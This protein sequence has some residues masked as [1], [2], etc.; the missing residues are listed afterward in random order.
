ML[1]N[2][3][4]VNNKNPDLKL[5]LGRT[6]SARYWGI[7]VFEALLCGADHFIYDL[8]CWLH[9]LFD[10][11][12]SVCVGLPWLVYFDRSCELKGRTWI[13]AL[14]SPMS[15][16]RLSRLFSGCFCSSRSWGIF[17]CLVSCNLKRII[18]HVSKWKRSLWNGWKGRGITFHPACWSTILHNLFASLAKGDPCRLESCQHRHD[19]LTKCYSPSKPSI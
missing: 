11:L 18:T 14:T 4:R 12:L 16:G 5:G 7:A 19:R 13:K 9:I 1:W 17:P 10:W 8:L 15:Q 6:S 2:R 3:S